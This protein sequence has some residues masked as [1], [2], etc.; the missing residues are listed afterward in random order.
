MTLKNILA[1][2]AALALIAT[3]AA[4]PMLVSANDDSKNVK[5]SGT[6]VAIGNNGGV[7][8]RGAEVTSISGS[9][10]TARTQWGDTSIS[11]TVDTDGDTN[12]IDLGGDATA[13]ADINSGETISFSGYIDSDSGA[14]SVDADVVRNWSEGEK[15]DNRSDKAE[16]KAEVSGKNFWKDLGLKF[17]S[18][19]NWGHK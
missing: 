18:G 4:S 3:V 12:F 11:W 7:L 19:F 2:G 17:K 15:H 16:V 9:T 8:V 5:T 14:F 13:L 10:V 6:S 1:S